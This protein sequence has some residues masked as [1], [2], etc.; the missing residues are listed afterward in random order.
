MCNRAQLFDLWPCRS[1]AAEAELGGCCV[2]LLAFDGRLH[3]SCI[4][5]CKEGW[6]CVAVSV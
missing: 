5:T 3:W 4:V 6:V 2:R 1:G